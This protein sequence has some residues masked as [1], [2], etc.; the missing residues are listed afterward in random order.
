M[1]LSAYDDMMGLEFGEYEGL[2]GLFDPQMLKEALVASTAGGGAILL[3]TYGMK[4]LTELLGV[5]KEEILFIG[6]RIREGG[7]DYPVKQAGIDCIQ[8]KSWEDTALAIQAI[9]YVS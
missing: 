1:N 8:V 9:I 7:N 6:D 5:T 3:A 4:K 2:S